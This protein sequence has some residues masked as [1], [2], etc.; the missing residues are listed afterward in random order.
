MGFSFLFFNGA[1]KAEQVTDSLRI[2]GKL[3]TQWQLNG[4][5][6]GA[7]SD[8]LLVRRARIDG[9]WRPYDWAKLMLEIEMADGIEA[10]DLYMRF[11]P[12]DGFDITVG[13]FKKPFS[14]IRMMSP[15]DLL[16]PERGLMDAQVT[17][18]TRY[19]G[20]GARDMG[21]MV[22]GTVLGPAMLED[23]LKLKYSLGTFSSLPGVDNPYRDI[24]GRTQLRLFKG[25]IVA[26]N[27]SH[28]F[29]NENG[30]KSGT[31]IGGDI[32]WEWDPFKL[33]VESA[34]GDNVNTGGKLWGGHAT[35]S[36][37]IPFLNDWKPFKKSQLIP[38]LMFEAFNDNTESSATLDY[39]LAAALNF[40]LNKHV[41]FVL[42]V[43][44]TWENVG[45]TET[46]TA[47]PIRFQLQNNIAF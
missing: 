4:S 25:L 32:K 2:R 37:E 39:R 15:W 18:R 12:F 29:Y 3:Q 30:L 19:G 45:D 28:K 42:S 46:D 1:A 8:A 38:A 34:W 9:T 23:P 44:K 40:D 13:S 7:W 26:V 27:A 24:V 36:Y 14:R 22:S 20:F 5:D 21:L 43:D 11:E 35:A 16:I 6:T 41:R 31:L 33:Q 17:R 47:N 10:R